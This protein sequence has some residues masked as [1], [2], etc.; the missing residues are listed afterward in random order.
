MLFKKKE[1][2][3]ILK[4]EGMMCPHCE[5][6]VKAAVEAVEGVTSAIPSHKKNTVTVFGQCDLEKVREVITAQGYQVK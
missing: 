5:A 2:G 4:V 6:R 1:A 3:V